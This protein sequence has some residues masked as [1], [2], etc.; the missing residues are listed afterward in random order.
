[1]VGRPFLL[2]PLRNEILDRSSDMAMT[3]HA[4]HAVCDS[5]RIE[6]R[7]SRQIEDGR[8][9]NPEI[10]QG[11]SS[12]VGAT[13]TGAFEFHRSMGKFAFW[14]SSGL[15]MGCQRAYVS[16]ASLAPVQRGWLGS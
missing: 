6:G 9:K 14:I 7:S 15:T 12:Q 10:R 4:R 8:K 1:M 3:G 11:R 2:P 13:A 5:Q 16:S